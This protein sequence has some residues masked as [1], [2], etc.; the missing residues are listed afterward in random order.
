MYPIK[1]CAVRLERGKNPIANVKCTLIL[2]ANL[3]LRDVSYG[4]NY[5]KI[6]MIF[7]PAGGIVTV[8]EIYSVHLDNNSTTRDTNYT[9]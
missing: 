8:Q 3:S 2:F 5:G 4:N 7:A 9:S 1:V 6:R